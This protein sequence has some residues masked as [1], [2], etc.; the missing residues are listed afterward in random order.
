VICSLYAETQE[1]I[2]KALFQMQG[3]IK[4]SKSKPQERILIKDIIY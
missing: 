4:I 1:R 2:D 3:S